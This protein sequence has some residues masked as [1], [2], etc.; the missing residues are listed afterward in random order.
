MKLYDQEDAIRR[1]DMFRFKYPGIPNRFV[2]AMYFVYGM[3][4]RLTFPG[5]P[6]YFLFFCDVHYSHESAY[7]KMRWWGPDFRRFYMSLP[8]A[9]SSTDKWEAW[10]L[11]MKLEHQGWPSFA[12]K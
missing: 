3:S 8:L 10:N 5:E 1:G 9:A 11:S 6:E 7:R 4:L 12:L 2:P